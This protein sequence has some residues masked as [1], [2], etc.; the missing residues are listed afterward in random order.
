MTVFDVAAA[1]TPQDSRCSFS[2]AVDR[3]ARPDDQDVQ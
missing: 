1:T 3:L 2:A